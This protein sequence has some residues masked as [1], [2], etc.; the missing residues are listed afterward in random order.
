MKYLLKFKTCLFIAV[1]LMS[2]SSCQDFL[3]R[4]DPGSYTLADFYENDEQLLQSVNV[5]YN[6]P[7]HDFSRGFIGVGDGQSGNHY[8]GGG[9]WWML[10]HTESGIQE[11]LADMSAALWSVNARANTTLENINMYAGSGTTEAGRN[12]AKGEVLVWKAMSYFFS[13]R[14][15]GAIPIIHDNSAM[16][17]SGEYNT[18]FRTKIDKVYDYIVMT[19]EQA[20]KWLPEQNRPGRIDRYSAYGL[21]AKVYLTKS[22]YGQ[23]GSRNQA[24]LDKAKE[25]AA[26]VINESGRE[27]EPEYSDIF[28]GSNNFTREALISWHW[29][30]LDDWTCANMQQSDLAPGGFD[31]HNCWGQWNGPSIDL[32]NA[33]GEDALKLNTRNNND[34]RRKAT[35]MMYGDVYEYFWRDKPTKPKAGSDTETVTFSNGFDVTMFFVDVCGQFYC[36]T[37]ANAVKHLAGNNADHIAE[38][39]IPMP[40]QMATGLSTHILRLA[41]VYLV[42]AEAVLGNNASTSDAGALKAFNA[43]RSRAGVPEKTSITFDDIFLE[44]RLEL[45]YEGDFWYDFVRL[46]YYNSNDALDRLNRQERRNYTGL[47][48]YTGFVGYLDKGE[49]GVT[50]GT[51]GLPTPRINEDQN[52]GQPFLS[53]SIFEVP[54]P[55]TDLNMNPS[56]L[57]EPQ[58]FDISTLSYK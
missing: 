23:S 35:M 40:G 54:F 42:Y 50:M 38:L 8:S 31:E 14:I 41:D 15:Y 48:S 1:L 25:Y 44:R 49:E 52:T 22:G 24:D 26:K 12:T 20:I 58:D 10:N 9:G 13:V 56:L 28:R 27:L 47:I 17:A 7:W 16:M 29:I 51:D 55:Q 36:P 18:L 32:Q 33:F 4:P 30:A 43:V 39:G 53:A 46:A 37:G 45:A 34:K 21:L 3:N 19:L 11:A 57:Q 2:L 5:L 6:S